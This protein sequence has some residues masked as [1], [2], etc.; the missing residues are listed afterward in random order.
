MRKQIFVRLSQAGLG[1]GPETVSDTDRY[2]APLTGFLRK[3]CLQLI[4][5][6]LKFCAGTQRTEGGAQAGRWDAGFV[7][8]EPLRGGAGGL[9]NIFPTLLALAG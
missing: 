4:Q 7:R 9:G 8:T 2:V 1:S 6:I 3:F 5:Y